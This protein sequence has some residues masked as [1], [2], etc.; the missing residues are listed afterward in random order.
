MS[1]LTDVWTAITDR[2][3]KTW[4]GHLALGLAIFGVMMLFGATTGEAAAAGS[5][6]FFGREVTN[7]EP[8]VGAWLRDRTPIPMEK[9]AD[10]FFDFWIP[11]FVLVGLSQIL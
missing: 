2:N 1:K 5:F 8:Y 11:M 10:G 7:I 9:I 3:W 4:L 6:Y